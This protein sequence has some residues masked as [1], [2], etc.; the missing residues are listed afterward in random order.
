MFDQMDS[1]RQSLAKSQRQMQENLQQIAQNRQDEINRKERS[2]EL[3]E[4][5][6]RQNEQMLKLQQTEVDFLKSISGDTAKLVNLLTNLEQIN[7]MNGTITEA[8]ML[9]IQQRLDE[10]I[11]NSGAANV[12]QIFLDEVKKQI[13]EK[14]VGFGVQFLITGLKLLFKANSVE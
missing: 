14:G 10:L 12:N 8:N 2:N 5:N 1:I 7:K 11:A 9:L 6:L 4:I 13:V 3:L